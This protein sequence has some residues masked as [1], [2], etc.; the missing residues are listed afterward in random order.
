MGIRPLFYAQVGHRFAFASEPGALLHLPW[1]SRELSMPALGEYLEFRYVHAPRTLFE[2][3]HAV[4]PGGVLR[5]EARGLHLDL[6]ARSPFSPPATP[7]P[8]SID[9]LAQFD[10]RFRRAVERRLDPRGGTGILLSGG[11]DSSLIAII[12][13]Q[14]QPGLPSYHVS[15]EDAGADEAAFAA[16][17]ASLLGTNHR[18]LKLN[19]ADFVGAF[20]A[21]VRAVGTPIPDP[22]AIPQLL[23]YREIARDVRV[24][25]S[26]DGGDEV[27]GGRRIAQSSAALARARR[28]NIVPR[29]LRGL[30]RKG[31]SKLGMPNLAFEPE[32]LGKARLIGGSEVFRPDERARLF[33][34]PD[35]HRPQLRAEVLEPLYDGLNTDPLN[36]VLGIYQRGWLPQDS[37]L[38]SDRASASVGLEVRYPV[39]DSS[40][41]ALLNNTPGDWKVRN[42]A[43]NTINKWPVR[44]LLRTKLPNNLVNRRK[45]RMP[46]PL[47]QW[48]RSSGRPFLKQRAQ[49]L[50]A[51]RW[52]LWKPEEVARLVREHVAGDADH[53][54]K[55]WCL[56]FLDGWLEQVRG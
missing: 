29:P 46:S 30:V 5:V 4:P 14:S 43:I 11:V 56:L 22:A 38:R 48:L 35:T 42:K 36:A 24:V 34:H 17:V 31:V 37:L 6:H 28:L 52:G 13:S 8:T 9:T 54:A 1:V 12:A 2:S 49:A 53:G 39:L 23:T 47:N 55:L 10:Q 41:V 21:A 18:C 19:S 45:Q 27:F 40:V 15:L 20:D 7:T 51:D 25:L 33:R 44:Q 3:I 16:R 32:A 26:G 50:E